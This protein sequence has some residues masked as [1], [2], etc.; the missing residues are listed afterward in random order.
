MQEFYEQSTDKG[1]DIS[2]G[3]MAYKIVEKN[4]KFLFQEY[5]ADDPSDCE[6]LEVHDIREE[7]EK[8]LKEYLNIKGGDTNE[9]QEN[10]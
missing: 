5:L 2:E 8:S 7:A 3:E 4:G 6:T 1:H 9:I 10:G